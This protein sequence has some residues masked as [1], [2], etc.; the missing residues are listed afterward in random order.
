ME[1]NI[2]LLEDRVR[3]VIDRIRNLSEEDGRLKEEVESL[4]QEV[5]ILEKERE[6]LSGGLS[7]ERR[8]SEAR[9][10]SGML[11]EA[12]EELRKD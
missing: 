9:E 3:K 4:R 8:E 2:K 12:I 1:P 11:R 5:A 10:I 6:K 7:P